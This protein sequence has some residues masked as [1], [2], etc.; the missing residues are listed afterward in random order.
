MIVSAAH[1]IFRLFLRYTWP[2]R[3]IDK[4]LLRLARCRLVP[5]PL[6]LVFVHSSPSLT[7]LYR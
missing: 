4:F 7:R 5:V 1:S 2:V 6:A 3:E